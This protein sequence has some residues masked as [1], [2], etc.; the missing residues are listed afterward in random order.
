MFLF[1]V[2]YIELATVSYR[3]LSIATKSISNIWI[4]A[5][6]AKAAYNLAVAGQNL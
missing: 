3:I 4:Q 5:L 6:Y 2:E 1:L